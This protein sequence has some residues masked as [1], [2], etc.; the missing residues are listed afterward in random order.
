[1][2]GLN[3][4]NL[5]LRQK[6]LQ[7]NWIFVFLVCITASVGFIMLYSA[8]NGSTTPWVSRQAIRFSAGL[9][10]MIVVALTDV[11]LWHRGAAVVR[12]RGG[13]PGNRSGRIGRQYKN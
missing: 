12:N 1:M 13:A 4:P 2:D 11:R 8:A 5:T 9:L 10:L 3:R 7:I 6:L